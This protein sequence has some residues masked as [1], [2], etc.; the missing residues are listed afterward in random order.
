MRGIVRVGAVGFPVYRLVVIAVALVMAAALWLML[1]RTRLGA[2]IRAGVDNTEMARGMG[3][4]VS[5][6]FTCVFCLGA[7]L[8]GMGGV[9]GGP[10]LSVYPGLDND[11]LPLALVVVIL[12]GMGS[13]VGAVS[14][15]GPGTSIPAGTFV[16]LASFTT[17]NQ[18]L[19]R[20]LLP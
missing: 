9:L 2:M 12:G 10:I 11:M 13:F 4:P 1:E 15:F 14:H 5:R 17:L 20:S 8:A 19:P 16:P 18:K 6:L 3:I 7:G